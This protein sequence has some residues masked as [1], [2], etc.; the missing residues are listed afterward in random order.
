MEQH[1]DVTMPR[2]MEHWQLAV[3]MCME[4][5]LSAVWRILDQTAT[6]L[7]RPFFQYNLGEPLVITIPL[8]SIRQ[9]NPQY[10]TITKVSQCPSVITVPLSTSRQFG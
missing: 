6:T 7:L 1:T 2:S 4:T 3:V 5:W 9:D 8:H 10:P